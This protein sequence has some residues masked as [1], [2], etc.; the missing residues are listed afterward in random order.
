MVFASCGTQLLGRL[1]ADALKRSQM[2]GCW[3]YIVSGMDVRVIH[4]HGRELVR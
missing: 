4:P 2:F 3:Q 1:A